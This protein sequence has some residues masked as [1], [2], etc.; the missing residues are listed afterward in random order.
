MKLPW[1]KRE[2]IDAVI[3]EF[4]P[5]NLDDEL[6]WASLSCVRAL[7]RIALGHPEGRA[8]PH[9]EYALSQRIARVWTALS[10]GRDP[11]A[12]YEIPLDD[13]GGPLTADMQ[14]EPSYRRMQELL[15]E[16]DRKLRAAQ[17]GQ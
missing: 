10:D 7:S 16:A 1:T 6:S 2:I 8:A 14:L 5:V 4:R 17:R 11:N 13:E 9:V 3:T 15:D 12:A